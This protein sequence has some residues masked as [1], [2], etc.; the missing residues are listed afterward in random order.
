VP[1]VL[2]T[3]VVKAGA[4]AGVAAGDAATATSM[5]DGADGA[6]C[7]CCTGSGA[8][9]EGC[10]AAKDR[11]GAGAF[12]AAVRA[13]AAR[14]GADCTASALFEITG[15]AVRAGGWSAGRVTLPE[16]LKF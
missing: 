5:V 4:A 15:L 1:A 16:R 11:L 14:G 8:V 9:S 10:F 12:A 7:A 2:S 13:G 6:R 3:G